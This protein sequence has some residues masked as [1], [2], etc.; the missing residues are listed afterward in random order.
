MKRKKSFLMIPFLVAIV[1]IGLWIYFDT[2]IKEFESR[3]LTFSS[4]NVNNDKPICYI[5][6]CGDSVFKSPREFTLKFD[7][8]EKVEDFNDY[9]FLEFIK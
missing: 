6:H 5:T 4:H 1:F 7:E 8:L 2:G 3:N 9:Y